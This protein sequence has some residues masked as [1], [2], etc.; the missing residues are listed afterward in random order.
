[1]L[2][3]KALILLPK[4]LNMLKNMKSK[5]VIRKGERLIQ[6]GQTKWNNVKGKLKYII[7]EQCIKT[8]IDEN[9]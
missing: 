6:I 9:S 3:K 5:I 2:G 1:M 4:D 8:G 7:N